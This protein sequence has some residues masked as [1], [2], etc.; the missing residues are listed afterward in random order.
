VLAYPPWHVARLSCFNLKDNACPILRPTLAVEAKRPIGLR[1][2]ETLRFSMAW[3][4]PC[5]GVPR[6]CTARTLCGSSSIS[7]HLSGCTICA[8]ARVSPPLAHAAAERDSLISS[9]PGL[10]LQA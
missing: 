4:F 7:M 2:D 1:V 5:A 9:L 6:S 3:G 10:Q 8:L